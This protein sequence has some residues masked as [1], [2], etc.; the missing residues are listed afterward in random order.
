MFHHYVY[1]FIRFKRLEDGITRKNDSTNLQAA[2][3]G[4]MNFLQPCLRESSS[5]AFLTRRCLP[6]LNNNAQV[7]HVIAS[8]CSW[9]VF[10]FF[11]FT[12]YA[13]F[14]ES[15]ATRHT[16]YFLKVETNPQLLIKTSLDL[17]RKF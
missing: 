10:F 17:R 6:T 4:V 14:S 8:L 11:F 12:L 16:V 2:N 9:F 1:L 15:S 3:Q 5:L 13:R 7:V